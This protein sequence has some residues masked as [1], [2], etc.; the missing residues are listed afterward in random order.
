MQFA[1][2][3]VDGFSDSG[4]ERCGLEASHAAQRASLTEKALATPFS[5]LLDVRYT[6]L[7][8]LRGSDVSL[9]ITKSE[10]RYHRRRSRGGGRSP[11][12]MDWGGSV[13]QPPQLLV[14][15]F[16]VITTQN[17]NILFTIE[18]VAQFI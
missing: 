18:M 2:T 13:F 10:S 7:H 5:F 8:S 11:Q 3:S 1:D 9:T 4:R 15:E 6:S 12:V 14:P 16:N 17:D